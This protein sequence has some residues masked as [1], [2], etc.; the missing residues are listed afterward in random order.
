ML[1]RQEKFSRLGL[2]NLKISLPYE[3]FQKR[4]KQNC[5]PVVTKHSKTLVEVI[6]T[7]PNR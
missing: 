5:D 2:R 4:P 1:R 3:N 7:D 6:Y